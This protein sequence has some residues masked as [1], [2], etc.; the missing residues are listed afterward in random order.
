MRSEGSGLRHVERFTVRDD[1]PLDRGSWPCT[2]PAVAQ[3]LEEGGIDV[4]AGVT[5]LVGE[6][7]SGKSTLVE[8]MARAYPRLG[9]APSVGNVT[10]PVGAREDSPL[11]R[12]L[13][14]RTSPW[15]SPA[16]FFLRAELMH[17]WL[18][19]R[20]EDPAWRRYADV[21][22]NAQSHG[23]SFLAIISDRFAEV[24]V[25]FLDEPEAALSFTSSL[26][27][28]ALLADMAEEGSQVVV[29]THSPLLVTTPGATILEL[30]EWGIRPVSVEECALVTQWRDF[31]DAPERYLR[32]LR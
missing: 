32:H 3:V 27:L 15:A 9:H 12:H 10:G 4:P 21:D 31:L 24:G 20:S 18:Q 14:A 5:L 6:N 8:A 22:W 13:R 2:V 17:G 30:G 19:R 25:F 23:E 26:A 28:V 16:G 1:L 7:G 29:A 11:W